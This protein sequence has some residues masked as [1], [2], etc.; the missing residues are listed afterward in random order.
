VYA[1]S[2]NPIAYTCCL[3]IVTLDVSSFTLAS[4]GAVITAG[5]GGATLSR[6]TAATCPAGDLDHSYTEPGGCSISHRL[7][8]SFSGADAWQG[9]YSLQ[10]AGSDCSCF[11]GALG[12]PCVN[13]S[14]P[15][16]ATR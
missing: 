15:V 5:P 2:G 11:G 7:V 13:Q 1:Q 14:F 10:F 16:S 8:G 9:T 3:G 12:T 6:P 4:D